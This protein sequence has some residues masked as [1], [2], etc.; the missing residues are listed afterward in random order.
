MLLINLAIFLFFTVPA[1]AESDFSGTWKLDLLETDF[2]LL[3]A[4]GSLFGPDEAVLVIEQEG[5][6]INVGLSQNGATGIIKTELIYRADGSECKNKLD[7]YVLTSVLKWMGEDLMVK[8]NLDME[9]FY[10]NLEDLWVLS[11]D[12]NKLTINRNF[13]S[14]SGK[15]VQK[16]VFNKQ[17]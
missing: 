16:W 12:G 8:S 4:S 7:E 11:E 1:L 3:E 2:G 6:V 10:P 14:E 13:S 17:Q 9:P 5:S 15:D